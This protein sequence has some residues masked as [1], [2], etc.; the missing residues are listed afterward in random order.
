MSDARAKRPALRPAQAANWDLR[1]R[2]FDAKF[3]S[4]LS[5]VAISWSQSFMISRICSWTSA[6]HSVSDG[7]DKH[8]SPRPSINCNLHLI[9]LLHHNLIALRYLA[10]FRLSLAPPRSLA[11]DR[12]TSRNL[13]TGIGLAEST[14]AFRVDLAAVS[15]VDTLSHYLAWVRNR[16]VG[17]PPCARRRRRF[18]GWRV[19]VRRTFTVRY[20]GT[21]PRGEAQ[22]ARCSGSSESNTREVGWGARKGMTFCPGQ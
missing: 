19:N 22:L 2:G 17:C 8:P 14:Q 12:S 6:S 10:V 9:K 16:T 20:P 3:G 13:A 5:A 11:A 21:A 18:G 4:S 1:L 15:L 7:L